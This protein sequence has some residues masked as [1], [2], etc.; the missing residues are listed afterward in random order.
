MIDRVQA[1]AVAEEW[2]DDGPICMIPKESSRTL[3]R[4]SLCVHRSPDSYGL[5]QTENSTAK[6]RCC[7]TTEMGLRRRQASSSRW[8]MSAPA[9][10]T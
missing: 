8:S 5:D 4:M 6:R 1:L 3:P 9:S 2:L 7:R 10:R